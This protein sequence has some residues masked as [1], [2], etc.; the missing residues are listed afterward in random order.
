MAARRSRQRF[1]R[2]SPCKSRAVA[3]VAGSPP[4][5]A[6]G[7][8]RQHP[9]RH[10]PGAGPVAAAARHRRHRRVARPAP[11]HRPAPPRA[12]A[13]R[14]AA[15]GAHRG[16]LGRRPPAAPLRRWPPDAPSLGLEPPA[17]PAAGADARC[18]WPRRRA[19]RATTPPSR[20][21]PG[22]SRRRRL[23][24]RAVVPRGARRRA[25]RAGLRPDGGRAPTTARSRSWPSPTAR[26]GSWPRRTPSWSARSTGAWSRASSSR[27]RR[28]GRRL[29]HPRA[30]RTLSGDASRPDRPSTRD[31]AHRYRCQQGQASCSTPRASPSWRCASPCAPVAARASRTRCSST[32]TSPATTSWP[33]SAA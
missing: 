9:L 6:E 25:R 16:P 11:E 18:S 13:R 14:R 7:A 17:V 26:S 29:P 5:R 15:R 3:D 12:D 30:P 21:G 33:S 8:R 2:S 24:R 28:R 23:R 32:P 22:P 19:R 31:H 20:A 27:R 10:L 1:Y 4:R